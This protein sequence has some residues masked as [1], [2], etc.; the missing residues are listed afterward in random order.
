MEEK[1]VKGSKGRGGGVKEGKQSLRSS[2]V[3]EKEFPEKGGSVRNPHQKK[4]H[5]CLAKLWYKKNPRTGFFLG[6]RGDDRGETQG[7]GESG[8]GSP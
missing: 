8:G 3:G 1:H 4:R 5:D 7:V 2:I 6:Q